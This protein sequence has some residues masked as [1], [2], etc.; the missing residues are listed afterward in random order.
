MLA[1]TWLC[2]FAAAVSLPERPARAREKWEAPR[3]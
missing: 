2:L 1:I 3:V